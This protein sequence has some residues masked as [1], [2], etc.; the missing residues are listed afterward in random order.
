[1]AERMTIGEFAAATWLSPKALRLYDQRAL[2]SPDTVDPSSGYRKYSPAQVETARLITLLRRIDM[3]LEEISGLL[4][5]SPEQQVQQIACF[6]RR[7]AE[8]H[9]RRQS[10]AH[11]LEHALLSGSMEGEGQPGVSTFEVGARTVCETAL[12]TSTRHTA[13]NELPRLIQDDAARLF[14]LAE[15]RGGHAGSLLVIYHG[16]VGW[17]SDGPI[18]VCVPIKE[19]D[20]AHRIE[21]EHQELFTGVLAEDVQFPRIL[22]AFEAVTMRAA[23]LGLEPVGPPREVY[24]PAVEGEIPRCEVA[25]PVEEMER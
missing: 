13:A 2:L 6:R 5:V 15:E 14:S 23:Q 19:R 10:L 7:E 18:E 3:P 21:P 9:A 22:A 16:Q 11:F 12:L 17:E 25:L 4:D 8:Q 20:R 1:M 24:G